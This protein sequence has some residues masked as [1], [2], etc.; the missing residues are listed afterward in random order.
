MSLVLF[1][2]DLSK[3][4]QSQTYQKSPWK[5]L[6]SE[7]V[8]CL[9]VLNYYD[10]RNLCILWHVSIVA[11]NL[12]KTSRGPWNDLCTVRHSQCTCLGL[13]H[14]THATVSGK[15]KH[16]WG[17]GESTPSKIVPKGLFFLQHEFKQRA[18]F[19][20]LDILVSFSYFITCSSGSNTDT[21]WVRN[22]GLIFNFYHTPQT[23]GFTSSCSTNVENLCK[24]LISILF[25]CWPKH[26]FRI[27]KSITEVDFRFL[28]L[29]YLL[30]DQTFPDLNHKLF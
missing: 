5:Y 20:H 1:F 6:S 29:V 10:S 26:V 8:T 25:E 11:G 24:N 7:C 4:V 27:K 13:W 9:M 14:Y 19:P 2:S 15:A 3:L 12:V 17:T 18:Q 23:S 21:T 30:F 22:T 28:W 16:T